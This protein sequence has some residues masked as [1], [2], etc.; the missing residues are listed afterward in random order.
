MGPNVHKGALHRVRSTIQRSQLKPKD[1]FLEKLTKDGKKWK[2]RY[3]ELEASNLHYYE[4]KKYCDSIKLYCVPIKLSSDDHKVVMIETDKR[5]WSLRA[6]SESAADD[7]ITALQMH[8]QGT[9]R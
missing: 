5:V 1:G 2:K 4:G 9:A 8:S 6:E 7:W 3:F